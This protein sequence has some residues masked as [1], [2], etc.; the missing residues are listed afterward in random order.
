MGGKK[1]RKQEWNDLPSVIQE[2]S[3]NADISELETEVRK[4][5]SSFIKN[6]RTVESNYTG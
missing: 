5:K 3:V 6:D 2:S 1:K 4:V